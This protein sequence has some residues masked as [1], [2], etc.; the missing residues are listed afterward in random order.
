MYVKVVHIAPVP[1]YCTSKSPSV[2]SPAVVTLY[3]NP[4]NGVFSPT[5]SYPNVAKARFGNDVDAETLNKR[6]A[7]SRVCN[8]S[9]VL[10]DAQIVPP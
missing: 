10:Y 2:T 1:K 6:F 9:D 8:T 4:E 3:T 7:E 5:I